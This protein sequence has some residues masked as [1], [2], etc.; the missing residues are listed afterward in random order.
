M[1]TGDHI[2]IWTLHPGKQATPNVTGPHLE[3]R[4]SEEIRPALRSR[5][6]YRASPAEGWDQARGAPRAPPQ[7][8]PGPD[9]RTPDG[10]GWATREQGH[11]IP[12]RS[13]SAGSPAEQSQGASA[14]GR[15]PGRLSRKPGGW[16]FSMVPPSQTS[17]AAPAAPL[18][19][20]CSPQVDDHFLKELPLVM[21]LYFL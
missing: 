10:E 11:V 20:G 8:V 9:A 1:R 7:R 12:R 16:P 6:V 19:Y 14:P 15:R 3:Y 4:E 13:L 18:P 5:K 17:A 21:T 2:H